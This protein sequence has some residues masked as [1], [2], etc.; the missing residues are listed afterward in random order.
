M[1]FTDQL[2]RTVNL[3]APPQRIISLVPSQTELLYYLGLGSRIVG[4]TKFCVHPAE[5]LKTKSVVGGTKNFWFD[6]IERLKPDLI[7]GNKEENYEAGIRQLETQYPVWMSDVTDLTGA[8]QMLQQIAIITRTETVG[9]QLVAKI[10]KAF[11]ALPVFPT[12]RVLYLIWYPWMAAG[13][14]TF[15]HNMLSQL[16]LMNVVEHS[17]YPELTDEGI[18]KLNPEII[19]LSSEPF[20]FSKIHEAR[21]KKLLPLTR[22][23]PV[24]GEMF[25]W[26]GSRLLLAADYFKTLYF[27]IKKMKNSNQQL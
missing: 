20:P 22:V 25:S 19:F 23:V 26:Y 27:T 11:D 17:R 3:P 16:G 4:V 5:A 18:Q 8:L 6:V 24:D 1:E 12:K 13:T 14:N 7:I 10:R 21:L 9:D 2:N 15:I